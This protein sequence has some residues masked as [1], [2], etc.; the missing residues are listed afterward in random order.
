[1]LNFVLG[2]GLGLLRLR[3]FFKVDMLTEYWL[4]AHG[5]VLLVAEAT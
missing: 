5:K 4:G 2:M 3:H 1:M